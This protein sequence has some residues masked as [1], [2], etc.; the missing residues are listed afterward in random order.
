M[1]TIQMLYANLLINTIDKFT[2]TCGNKLLVFEFLK[3]KTT[4]QQSID[5]LAPLVSG[6]LEEDF[7]LLQAKSLPFQPV[8]FELLCENVT[9]LDAE[10]MRLFLLV[11]TNP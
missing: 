6:K 8:S 7:W 11:T 2:D 4:L 9:E 3:I 5:I 1:K 10:T